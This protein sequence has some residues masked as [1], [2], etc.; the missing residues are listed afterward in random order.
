MR[1]FSPCERPDRSCCARTHKGFA[2]A[3]GSSRGFAL[4]VCLAL[5]VLLT[6]VVVA[7]LSVSLSNRR[8]EA[9]RVGHGAADALA[10]SSLEALT[11]DLLAEVRAGSDALTVLDM[12]TFY[13][14][15]EVAT[16]PHRS[17]SAA[18]SNMASAITLIKQTMPG[19]TLFPDVAPYAAVPGGRILPAA[20]TVST[21]ATNRDG[22]FVA[23]RRWEAPR[24]LP[25]TFPAGG[26]PHWI[27][28]SRAG[29]PPVQSMVA[30]WADYATT[31]SN[32]VTGRI[33]FNVY[34]TG[35]LLNANV[36]GFPSG[37]SAVQ[38]SRLKGSQAG[39]DL[40]SL[41]GV[42]AATVDD[43]VKFR[44]PNSVSPQDYLDHVLG[45]AQPAGFA[46]NAVFVNR[47]DLIRYAE[48][49]NNGLTNA[50]P[51]LN[52]VTVAKN[53]PSWRPGYDA[54]SR[55]GG[56]TRPEFQYRARATNQPPLTVNAAA[57]AV[58]WLADATIT[59]YRSN[60][61]LFTYQVRRGEPLIQ[62]RF[63]LGRLA[64]IG[65][66]GPQNGGS[67][68]AIR[69]CFGLQWSGGV[70]QYVGASGGIKDTIA[71]LREVA[72]ARREPNF[73]ELLQ[74]GILDGSL[75]VSVKTGA[76]RAESNIKT[77]FQILQIGAGLIDQYDADSFPT[78]IEYNGT[79]GTP[80]WQ[81]VGVENLPYIESIASVAGPKPGEETKSLLTYILPRVW[82]PHRGTALNRPRIR[83][84]LVSTHLEARN[85][86]GIY[87]NAPNDPKVPRMVLV[88][89]R[90]DATLSS[91]ASAGF[92]E[93]RYPVASDFASALPDNPAGV[94]WAPAPAE[95]GTIGGSPYVGFRFPDFQIDPA[96]KDTSTDSER[97]RMT[98]RLGAR[99]G[100]GSPTGWGSVQM[101]FETPGG[102]WIPYAVF[103]GN[104]DPATAMAWN[105]TKA[106]GTFSASA[107]G[108]RS[109]TPLPW[110]PSFIKGEQ[111]VKSD[112]RCT[113]SFA[114][115]M[116]AMEGFEYSPPP[117]LWSRNAPTAVAVSGIGTVNQSR[118]G[119]GGFDWDA[120]GRSPRTM[121][122]VPENDSAD[123]FYGG[124]SFFSLFYYPAWL[125]RNF[126]PNVPSAS[127][128]GARP[129][130][131]VDVDGIRR[132]ADSGRYKNE[133]PGGN[134]API[135]GNPYSRERDRPTVLNR[136]F[137]SVA[138]MG[139][140]F[141]GLH[142]K[143]L[144]FF[145]Q[146]SA[147]AG[148]L[149]FFAV[150]DADAELLAGRLNPASAPMEVLSA[151]LNGS[152]I[153]AADPAVG[154]ISPSAATNL[155]TKLVAAQIPLE[156][157]ASLATAWVGPLDGDHTITN[158]APVPLQD[159]DFPNPDASRIKPYRESITRALVGMA[160]T[161]TW[162]LLVDLIAQSG[163][164]PAGES[165][166]AN[167]IVSGEK[168]YWL[169]L[170]IDRFSGRIL[171]RQM[172][173]VPE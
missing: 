47:L 37:L 169:H 4:V 90:A 40:R 171:S 106:G 160:D 137:E 131:Y 104:N 56:S 97:W 25:M 105:N 134:Q 99:V 45:G 115:Q 76:M 141:R 153:D 50:L 107:G 38:V 149:D 94:C 65:P 79:G 33:A 102:Q 89:V 78:V 82:N 11:G 147:D 74:A 43:L 103:N 13:P 163:R 72:A 30:G 19:Q 117:S 158:N 29:I 84:S 69:A 49:Q 2:G 98:L 152:P 168:R 138:D 71:T 24:L 133:L 128:S 121:N 172:E 91:S 39:A 58:R 12:T 51:F 154:T 6:F 73:F 9:A 113:R 32:A 27:Y 21:G 146:N 140:T 36:A 18:I 17:V 162:N 52:H 88:N 151:L 111:W 68:D 7:F 101:E 35:G 54:T 86:W 164:F 118:N 61:A 123:G 143:S 165:D 75:G 132:I 70:W 119:F 110:T 112:P 120:A 142:W 59:S 64:W 144:D 62:R 157:P 42:T 129:S 26:V 55:V 16:R 156:N 159:T 31:N 166:P 161:R 155:A 53:E 136:P 109:Y 28:V 96:K 8:I 67:A 41:P 167:F 20:S 57:L 23:A 108:L 14:K 15:A 60:G 80:Y 148:L 5:V 1:D 85:F 116:F 46:T 122:N 3:F 93:P 63:P 77:T 125:S 92:A 10:L 170:S 114:V 22:R 83:L 87:P 34:D 150:T 44:N 48:R 100:T 81:A 173:S 145:S 66:S 126:G 130:T 95:L 124:T 127:S 139:Y 135:E